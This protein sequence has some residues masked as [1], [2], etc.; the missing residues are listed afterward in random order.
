MNMIVKYALKELQIYWK[1]NVI[2][3]IQLVITFVICFLSVSTITSELKYFSKFNSYFG[4]EGYYIQSFITFDPER[5]YLIKD[6]DE[7]QSYLRSASVIGYSQVEN[8]RCEK[9]EIAY[10]FEVRAYDEDVIKR[11]TPSL[12]GGCWLN[13]TKNDSGILEAVISEN[14]FDIDIGDTI[15]INVYADNGTLSGE[16]IRVPAK[17]IGKLADGKDFY[18]ESISGADKMDY[19]LCYQQYYLEH[20]DNPILLISKNDLLSVAAQETD[21][22]IP[23]CLTGSSFIVYDKDISDN[24]REYNLSYIRANSVVGLMESLEV[25]RH[26][27]FEYFVG[28]ILQYLPALFG[29]IIFTILNQI[30]IRAITA[31][32]QLRNYAIFNVCGM[33]KK[34]CI[35]VSLVS[36]GIL[37]FLAFLFSLGGVFAFKTVPVS[38]NLV[39]DISYWQMLC[40][41]TMIFID[42]LLSSILPNT[43]IRNL[44]PKEILRNN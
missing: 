33:T 29:F 8:A 9:D 30:S 2:I 34:E 1:M 39:L 27:N 15:T 14:H 21:Y 25:M 23:L 5:I 32:M 20:A 44:T 24:E 19:R 26:N 38:Q 12:A 43:I 16:I 17:I 42:L 36:A 6:S 28:K 10:H 4:Q 35:L 37:S 41:F 7:L 22:E 3:F 31:K 11:Y 40:C 18:G 13:R